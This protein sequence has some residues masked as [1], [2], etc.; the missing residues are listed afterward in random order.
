MRDRRVLLGGAA[1]ALVVVA[2]NP[3]T[4]EIKLLTHEASDPAPR[5]MQAAVNLGFVGVTVLY[6]GTVKRLGNAR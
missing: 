6:T 5:R 1:L 3:P 4:A 2:A